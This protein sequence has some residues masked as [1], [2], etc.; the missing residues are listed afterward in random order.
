MTDIY[1]QHRAAFSQVSAYVITD[2]SGERQ[3]SIAFKF[4]KDGAGRLYCYFH[5]L[6]TA[7]VRGHANGYGYDKKS[8]AVVNALSKL[9]I[10]DGCDPK[11]QKLMFVLQSQGK[12]MDS[13]T[14]DN[15]LRNAGYNVLQAV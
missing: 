15:V 3:A 2:S 9:K 14:W 13:G 4:P 8:A 11:V 12:A 7:M 10:A 1:E 5:L 6:G